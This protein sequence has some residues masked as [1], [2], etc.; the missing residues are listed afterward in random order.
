[1]FDERGAGAL[2]QM[3]KDCLDAN[4]A[5]VP[6]SAYRTQEYQQ[7]LFDN[8]VERLMAE[9]QTPYELLEETA[10]KEVARPGTSEHQTGLAVDIVDEFY[11]SLDPVQEWM[12]TQRW[13]MQHCTEYGFIL[14]Y[15][16]GTSDITGIVYEP[17][18]YRYVGKTAAVEIKELGI[19][20]EEYREKIT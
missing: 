14:R 11:P 2:K 4:L 18:H 1:M 7:E 16:N 6:L 9:M 20:L 5:P 17:W 12:D 8:K 3:L 13:L 10:A 15:P 19:T